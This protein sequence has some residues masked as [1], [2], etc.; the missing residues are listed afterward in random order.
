MDLSNAVDSLNHEFLI[1]LL[2]CYGLDHYAGKYF[3]SCL[4]NRY[5]CCKI[6]NI[7]E[8]GRKIIATVPQDLYWVLYYSRCF[9]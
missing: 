5:Q 3:R 9:K 6:K 7:L 4:S 1:A 2:K 8:D